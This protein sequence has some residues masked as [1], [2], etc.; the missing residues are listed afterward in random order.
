MNPTASSFLGGTS[1]LHPCL[2]DGGLSIPN[3]HEGARGD[4]T[5]NALYR[6]IVNRRIQDEET[7]ALAA[8][9]LP[10]IRSGSLFGTGGMLD[11]THSSLLSRPSEATSSTVGL[12]SI[13]QAV[14]REQTIAEAAAANRYS[15]NEDG[16]A[17]KRFKRH[18]L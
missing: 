17:T 14:M 11:R 16:P 15:T 18:L 6:A 7:A 8:A 5:N 3:N 13:R 1:S 10:P 9:G 2:S 12:D 4:L